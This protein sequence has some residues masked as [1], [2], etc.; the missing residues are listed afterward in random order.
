MKTV[1][2]EALGL[3]AKVTGVPELLE[4]S[5]HGIFAEAVSVFGS[6]QNVLDAAVANVRA[7]GKPA[8]ALRVAAVAI[9][10]ERTGVSI[11]TEAVLNDDKTPKLDDAGNPVTIETE[12]QGRYVK[13]AIAESGIAIET[14]AAGSN[15]EVAFDA[16]SNPRTGSGAV[17]VGKAYLEAA[18]NK[19]NEGEA[20]FNKTIK[21]LEKHNPGVSVLRAEDGTPVVESFALAIKANQDRV[22]KDAQAQMG[23]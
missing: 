7:H 2:T 19:V 14:I 1:T 16:S 9:I 3:P 15:I 11:A 8:T 23:L 18:T 21:F 22:L 20:A 17:K 10:A 5:E 4:G 13:R 6:A 12:S